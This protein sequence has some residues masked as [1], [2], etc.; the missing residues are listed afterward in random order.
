MCMHR[1]YGTLPSIQTYYKTQIAMR[2]EYSSW[3]TLGPLAAHCPISCAMALYTITTCAKCIHALPM[4]SLHEV[5]DVEVVLHEALSWARTRPRLHLGG[6]VSLGLHAGL[7]GC[8]APHGLRG[9]GSL[10][11]R[12]GASWPLLLHEEL[13]LLLLLLLLSDSLLLLLQTQKVTWHYMYMPQQL[14]F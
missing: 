3:M 12:G 13:L 2:R 14:A 1:F 11:G 6:H 9:R 8:H 7:L 10:L 5:R 4:S